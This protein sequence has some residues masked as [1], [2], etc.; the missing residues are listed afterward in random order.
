MVERHV[1]YTS[2]VLEFCPDSAKLARECIGTALCLTGINLYHPS[3]YAEIDSNRWSEHI[4][5]SSCSET[6][7][8]IS[9]HV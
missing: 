2:K 6:M 7:K 4:F 3:N 1:I 9:T 5:H 8:I